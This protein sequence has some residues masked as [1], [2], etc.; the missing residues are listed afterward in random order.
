MDQIELMFLKF[1]SKI[2]RLPLAVRIVVPAILVLL[3]VFVALMQ[4]DFFA[5]FGMSAAEKEQYRAEQAAIEEQLREEEARAALIAQEET[6]GYKI[7]DSPNLTSEELQVVEFMNACEAGDYE[8]IAAYI[9]T[10]NVFTD[11]NFDEWVE[12]TGIEP[13]MSSE[14]EMRNIAMLERDVLGANK[15][16]VVGT[17]PVAVVWRGENTDSKVILPY[18]VHNGKLCFTPE[19]GMLENQ[20]YLIPCKNAHF[21][22]ADV[23]AYAGKT[24]TTK[25]STWYEYSF[26]RMPDTSV[27][28]FPITIDTELGSF[29]GVV[30]PEMKRETNYENTVI[31]D[32]TT[33]EIDQFSHNIAD[34]IERTVRLVQNRASDEEIASYMAI[35]DILKDISPSQHEEGDTELVELDSVT[36]VEVYRNES[37]QDG[38]VLGYNYHLN[39][40]NSVTC[41]VNIRYGLASGGECRRMADI[42]IRPIGDAWC[43]IREA[44][45][46]TRY[47][48]FTNINMLDPEW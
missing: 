22:G 3:I 42:T 35:G 34:A 45:N 24:V 6:N 41:K 44:R 39:A 30:T 12:A 7:F 40:D 21:A 27:D 16:D 37:V 29:T 10:P 25:T 38:Y 1:K 31:A 4:T 36:S 8:T 15:K 20:V 32:F 9:D 26:P 13:F 33:E 17:E 18:T 23:S 47:S 28:G 2:K 48:V 5:T 14:G 46:N 11:D 43:I 19:A